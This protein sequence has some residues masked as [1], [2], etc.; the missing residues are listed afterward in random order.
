MNRDTAPTSMMMIL[1]V[2]EMILYTLFPSSKSNEVPV[3]WI[4]VDPRMQWYRYLIPRQP[5]EC[6]RDQVV[7]DDVI[8]KVDALIGNKTPELMIAVRQRTF[9]MLPLFVSLSRFI[10]APSST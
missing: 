4:R 9:L 5:E 6:L 7:S 3:R 2:I 8:G 10:R 1:T